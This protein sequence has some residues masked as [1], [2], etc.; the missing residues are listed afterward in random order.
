MSSEIDFLQGNLPE[1]FLLETL[2]HKGRTTFVARVIN[3]KS[4]ERLVAKAPLSE[5]PNAM[6]RASLVKEHA[7]LQD[8]NSPQVVHAVQFDHSKSVLL[9][10]D[11][12]AVSLESWFQTQKSLTVV[13]ALTVTLECA[14]GLS[15]IHS[16]GVLHKDINPGNIL[17]S[18][19]GKTFQLCDLSIA[20]HESNSA[21]ESLQNLEGT[22]SFMAPEQTGRIGRPC[23]LRTD[24]FGLGAVLYFLLSGK[25]AND[26][27]DT[28]SYIHS[29]LTPRRYS[30]AEGRQDCPGY[31]EDFL[32]TLLAK[33]PNSRYQTFGGLMQDLNSCITAVKQGQETVFLKGRDSGRGFSLFHFETQDFKDALTQVS[34][35]KRNR[36]NT[37]ISG[38]GSP[39]AGKSSTLVELARRVE[40]ASVFQVTWI[41]D[42]KPSR[43]SIW[44]SVLNQSLRMVSLWAQNEQEE[45]KLKCK[46]RLGRSRLVLE[47]ICPDLAQ[48]L[49]DPPPTKSSPAKIAIALRVYLGLFEGATQNLILT[50]DNLDRADPET[51]S[52]LETLCLSTEFN[53]FTALFSHSSDTSLKPSF[54]AFLKNLETQSGFRSLELKPF[55]ERD[56]ATW[57]QTSLVVD[58]ALPHEFLA[59]ATLKTKGQPAVLRAL[60]ERAQK[61]KALQF[62]G[63]VWHWTPSLL[64]WNNNEDSPEK[65]LRDR[66][67]NLSASEKNVLAKAALLG[68]EFSPA[69]LQIAVDTSDTDVVQALSTLWRKGLLESSGESPWVP[70][71]SATDLSQE[72]KLKFSSAAHL[73]ICLSL[74]SPTEVTEINTGFLSN[75]LA[76]L[77]SEKNNSATHVGPSF[78]EEFVNR[79]QAVADL[80]K[81]E[82]V[83]ELFQRLVETGK[84]SL[85]CFEPSTAS[86]AFHLADDLA[87]T[88][89]VTCTQP[90][91]WEISL[92][93]LDAECQNR[94]L[95]AQDVSVLAEK[96]AALAPSR[97]AKAQVWE[98][99]STFLIS[100]RDYAR[101]VLVLGNALSILGVQIPDHPNLAKVTAQILKTKIVL[102][103]PKL[104]RFEKLKPMENAEDILQM[105]LMM[106]LIS[107]AYFT[108]PNLFPIVVM[109]M[110]ELTSSSGLT[111]FGSFAL[112]VL[113]VLE[114]GAFGNINEG[115]ALS[116]FGLERALAN[117]PGDWTGRILMVHNTSVRHWREPLQKSLLEFQKGLKLCLEVGDTEY[118][119][120]NSAIFVAYS[121]LSGVDLAQVT[122]RA[123]RAV[124]IT[125]EIKDR[126]QLPIVQIFGQLALDFGAKNSPSD[127]SVFNGDFLDEHKVTIEGAINSE[128]TIQCLFSLFKL[129]RAYHFNDNATAQMMI[130]KVKPNL[131]TIVGVAYVPVFVFYSALSNL[132]AG[133]SVSLARKS[134]KKLKTWAAHSSENY[135]HKALLVEA[136]LTRLSDRPEKAL[137]L[138][139]AAS[140]KAA[141]SGFVHEEALCYELCGR[142]FI[143]QG[144]RK[145]ATSKLSQAAVHYTIWGAAKKV[146]LLQEEF[147]GLV[148]LG[149]TEFEF[150]QTV[151]SVQT[152]TQTG[153]RAQQTLDRDFIS[154]ASR[155]L[156]TLMPVEELV[157]TALNLLSQATAADRICLLEFSPHGEWQIKGELRA[158]PDNGTSN[159]RNRTPSDPSIW[160]FPLE[161][162]S[163]IEE[164]KAPVLLKDAALD[165]PSESYFLSNGIKSVACLPLLS[166][167]TLVGMLYLENS[168]WSDVFQDRSVDL[169]MLFASQVGISLQNAE[170][171]EDMD[172]KVR[173]RTAQL[174]QE[175]ALLQEALS[176]KQALVRTL[177][178]DLKNYFASVL[179]RSEMEIEIGSASSKSF[180]KIVALT[181]KMLR[182]VNHVVTLEGLHAGKLGPTLEPLPVSELLST[183]ISMFEYRAQEKGIELIAVHNLESNAAFLADRAT[184]GVVVLG[185][186]ISNALKFT[187]RSGRVLVEFCYDANS[188]DIRM[189]VS[190]SGQ[191][192]PEHILRDLFSPTAKTTRVGTQGEVGTGFGMPLVKKY[193]D[194]MGAKIEVVSQVAS[195]EN[196]QSGTTFH[197]FLKKA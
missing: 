28:L 155:T 55:S 99:F 150:S 141:S 3:N 38:S 81:A 158:I 190:D 101:A 182:F 17:V 93:R 97:S 187:S 196:S 188:N 114:C 77:G 197:V 122:M 177:A 62:D 102:G 37:L 159:Q 45:W 9:M 68:V 36:Q 127:L 98:M 108:Q 87:R 131:D 1:G 20:A 125:N 186:L 80:W 129:V 189:S 46:S 167:E 162:R 172:R 69:V 32:N 50:L 2:L 168:T 39:L 174:V 111:E 136:E 72:S 13:E 23:D 70:W 145:L 118:A 16:K 73:E 54:S 49:G 12:Y 42:E 106:K 138:Y 142:Y 166:R 43:L 175:Q 193:L 192:I 66:L 22:L 5:F 90:L 31:V 7:L 156:Q 180:Q 52:D 59:F 115:Y 191:G 178:H 144:L 84:T 27:T 63:Q 157:K 195:D 148:H 75:Y 133:G 153:R 41:D 112:S 171:F 104:K 91:A 79:S 117:G 60:V 53:N 33:N 88:H 100:G 64:N 121:F 173:E 124:N 74:L 135:A 10:E 57:L 51:L 161:M 61:E 179:L 151:T 110:V 143:G 163:R 78:R 128:K 119:S 4:N 103:G 165:C 123:N 164:C 21:L 8:F 6:V 139:E 48:L 107:A 116:Q 34:L 18:D 185:N 154:R 44:K 56:V 82:R 58:I 120:L 184:F 147:P 92:G 94:I 95:S 85:S 15:A 86:R 11:R 140:A 89:K 126:S 146:S 134:L 96:A 183:V 152:V 194:S 30:V 76:F 181:E 105:R 109:R 26:G 29:I 14:K 113:G 83:P 19:N 47:Q 24:F 176:E 169:F 170:L 35:P 160:D 25:K 40:N 65:E 149:S 132:R 67:Q 130:E 137:A 71:I